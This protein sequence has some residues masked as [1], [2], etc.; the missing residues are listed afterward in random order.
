MHHLPTNS[1]PLA[2][3]QKDLGLNI[4]Q[5]LD[6]LGLCRLNDLASLYSIS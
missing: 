1:P 2:L 6:A 3:P 4:Q 5:F